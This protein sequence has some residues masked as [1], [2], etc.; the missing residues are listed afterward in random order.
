MMHGNQ[1][2][3]GVPRAAGTVNMP[4]AVIWPR[5]GTRGELLT[6]LPT[7]HDDFCCALAASRLGAHPAARPGAAQGSG[8]RPGGQCARRS[9]GAR[10]AAG[11]SDRSPAPAQ[12]LPPGEM[13]RCIPQGAT[14]LFHT[15]LKPA[16]L[17]ANRRMPAPAAGQLAV[18]LPGLASC[19][20]LWPLQ[21]GLPHP[22][23]LPPS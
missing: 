15:V 13:Q 23:P 10:A 7:H 18:D 6:C 16:H 4:T 9:G 11:G 17:A 22:A 12:P 19:L 1:L 21:S 2:H 5:H 8:S 14:A 20:L 3:A